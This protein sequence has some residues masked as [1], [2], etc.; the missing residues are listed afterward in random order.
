MFAICGFVEVSNYLSQQS[1]ALDPIIWLNLSLIHILEP[2]SYLWT[3]FSPDILLPLLLFSPIISCIERENK[4]KVTI[5]MEQKQRITVKQSVLKLLGNVSVIHSVSFL[6][7]IYGIEKLFVH[8]SRNEEGRNDVISFCFIIPKLN[9]GFRLSAAVEDIQVP[10][11]HVSRI[12]VLLSLIH[13][14]SFSFCKYMK[15]FSFLQVFGLFLLCFQ[16]KN[17]NLQKK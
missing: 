13:I 10:L 1:T 2:V 3:E 9:A 5:I 4:Q 14:C 6:D 17:V 15:Y 11:Y 7:T 12:G 8:S 16:R